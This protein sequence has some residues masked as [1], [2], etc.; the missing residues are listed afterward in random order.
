M[1]DVLTIVRDRLVSLRKDLELTAANLSEAAIDVLP[2]PTGLA[3]HSSR[4]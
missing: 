3:S 4:D 2:V 1:T